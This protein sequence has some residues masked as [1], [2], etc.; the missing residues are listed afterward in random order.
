[1]NDSFLKWRFDVELKGILRRANYPQ[2]TKGTPV[3]ARDELASKSAW[4]CSMF[5]AY[6]VEAQG[7]RV[8]GKCRYTQATCK[9]FSTSK[10]WT[11]TTTAVWYGYGAVNIFNFIRRKR[12]HKQRKNSSSN[13]SRQADINNCDDWTCAVSGCGQ[14]SKVFKVTLNSQIH[15]WPIWQ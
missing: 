14:H 9:Y 8:Q 11:K 5:P 4:T 6:S 2:L 12:Q 7:P 3:D 10:T 1:M 15:I 13:S